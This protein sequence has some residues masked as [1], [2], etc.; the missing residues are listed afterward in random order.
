MLS[1]GNGLGSTRLRRLLLAMDLGWMCLALLL[2]WCLRYRSVSVLWSPA[3]GIRVYLLPLAVAALSWSLL[4]SALSLDGFAG[5]W[6]IS[7]VASR[8]FVA[9]PISWGLG[10]SA[11][12]FERV[13]VSRLIL[14]LTVVLSALGLLL[15]RVAIA[16]RL[17]ARHRHGR[18]ERVFLLGE[19]RITGALE[20]KIASHP[21]LLLQVVGKFRPAPAWESV[22][23]TA[24]SSMDLLERIEAERVSHIVLAVTHFP[25]PELHE[26]IWRCRTRGVRIS[27]LP[28]P[29]ELYTSRP[30]MIELDNLPLLSLEEPIAS[31]LAAVSK[32]AFDLVITAVMAFPTLLLLLAAAAALRLSGVRKPLCAEMRCGKNG[33]PFAMWELRISR[34]DAELPT[35]QFWLRRL[36]VIDLPQLWNVIRGDMSLVGPRPEPP[37]RV[38]HYTD[39]QR[40]RL[41]QV[42]GMTGLA[43]VYDLRDGHSAEAKTHF[44][45]QYALNWTPLLDLSL[46]VQTLFTLARRGR[47]LD[48]PPR[49]Q[50][51]EAPT[52]ARGA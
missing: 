24:V 26:F 36:S 2:A 50:S 29:Y 37:D 11:L 30:R 9:L 35:L 6:R 42:P 27:V 13:Y 51:S 19:D 3:P 20:A 45:L 17:A 52:H 5:G 33:V 14:T 48:L 25:G 16:W 12:Y 39:W 38:K 21:E 47:R 15:L 43:Q 44:D 23:S 1:F 8:L 18:A 22:E 10:A 49:S 41:R 34:N 7:A 4:F 31:P 46:L 40:E 28:Q 32:R